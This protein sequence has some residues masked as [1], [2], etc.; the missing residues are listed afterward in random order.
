MRRALTALL[1]FALAGTLL[2]QAPVVRAPDSPVKK[3]LLGNSAVT[4][5]TF[6]RAELKGTTTEMS[7]GVRFKV[8]GTEI[9]ADEASL[10]FRAGEIRLR[11]DVRL[12][13]R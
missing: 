13:F 7:G 11:G 4:D 9:S 10:D 5:I 8:D 6:G 1:F 12:K 2:A 3:V